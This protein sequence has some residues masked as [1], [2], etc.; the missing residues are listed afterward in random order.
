MTSPDQAK[1]DLHSEMSMRCPP[2]LRCL[3]FLWEQ[4]NANCF[5]NIQKDIINR[6]NDQNIKDSTILEDRN[7]SSNFDVR[8]NDAL[9]EVRKKGDL[10]F[11]QFSRSMIFLIEM[12]I[13][14]MI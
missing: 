6:E 12:L 8:K 3:V 4:I 2:A 7:S 5:Q 1:T 9:N 10:N 11:A 13:V 14:H